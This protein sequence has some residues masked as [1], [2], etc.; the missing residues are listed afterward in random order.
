MM[1][2]EIDDEGRH[3]QE[4][5]HDERAPS[6]ECIRERASRHVSKKQND[7]IGREHRVD[8]KLGQAARLEKNRVDA[9][10]E[11]AG[12]RIHQPDR[13]VA[14]DYS[15]YG[16]S[17]FENRFHRIHTLRGANSAS[18]AHTKKKP[19]APKAPRAFSKAGFRSRSTHGNSRLAPVMAATKTGMGWRLAAPACRV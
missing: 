2:E 9:K 8:L 11:S 4:R 1:R 7:E 10:K 3:A 19:R 13:V 15:F 12:K 18:A 6:S 16:R 5:P 14:A 17:F